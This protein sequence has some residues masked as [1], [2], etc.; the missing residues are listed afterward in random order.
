MSSEN[1]RKLMQSM[2]PI[3]DPKIIWFAYYHG[4][5]IAFWV[6]IPDTNQLIVKYM[7]GKLTVLVKLLFVWNRWRK[8]CNTLFVIVFGVAHKPPR[9]GGE[10]A[11]IGG[12]TKI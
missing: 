7:N 11:L 8:R 4:R 2:K 9:N 10:A 5:P 1:A 12:A 6:N 3:I